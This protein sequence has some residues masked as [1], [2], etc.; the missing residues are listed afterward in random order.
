MS[1]IGAA[2]AL[3]S[4][5]ARSLEFGK[6][7][8]APDDLVAPVLQAPVAIDVPPA[9][10]AELDAEPSP[11]SGD[12]VVKYVVGIDG[13]PHSLELEQR[14]DPRL[15][16]LALAAVA[17]LRYQPARWQGEPVEVVLRQRIAFA[18]RARK[19]AP[20]DHDPDDDDDGRPPDPRPPS[21]I[22]QRPA[23]DAPLFG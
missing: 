1:E 7:E 22:P 11:P 12:V 15:D 3:A 10:A 19:P 13:V 2:L 8:L 18:P 9:L 21:T 16:A 23:A 6:P 20:A 14:V 4:L 5:L 17:K